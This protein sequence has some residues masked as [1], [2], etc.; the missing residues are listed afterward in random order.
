MIN[1]LWH[2]EKHLLELKNLELANAID[3]K[4]NEIQLL[5]KKLQH[6]KEMGTMEQNKTERMIAL[7]EGKQKENE[8]LHLKVAELVK[9]LLA[10]NA[11]HGDVDV[12]TEFIGLSDFSNAYIVNE[13]SYKD[14]LQEA[15]KALINVL[16]DGSKV[17]IGV[18]RLG[19]LEL[20]ASQVA[21]RREYFVEEEVNE[22][23]A[24]LCSMW[25]SCQRS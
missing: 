4:S 21:A 13:Q 2:K 5:E 1:Q 25:E 17:S 23:A 14:E 11:R 19:N 7:L 9:Q 24:E 10:K 15:R 20:K 8:K 12:D 16:R 3:V 6:M 18:K 22:R